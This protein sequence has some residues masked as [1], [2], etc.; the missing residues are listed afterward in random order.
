M[1]RNQHRVLSSDYISDK[2]Q[3][4]R[5]L[6]EGAVQSPL[7]NQKPN[8]NISYETDFNSINDINRR[9]KN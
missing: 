4:T 9:T 2:D 3:A 1:D 8:N 6:T 7:L 5:Y